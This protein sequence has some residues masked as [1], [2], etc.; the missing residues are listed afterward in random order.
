MNN[1][2]AMIKHKRMI[3][4]KQRQENYTFEQAADFLGTTEDQ[5]VE[6]LVDIGWLFFGRENEIT[7]DAIDDDLLAAL[8]CDVTITPAGMD[9]LHRMLSD[10]SQRF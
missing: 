4:R 9:E 7:Q 8:N 1:I 6:A 3:R 5:L 10:D 2:Q